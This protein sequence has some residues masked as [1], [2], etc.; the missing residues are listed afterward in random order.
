M[1][2]S[3][4]MFNKA[5]QVLRAYLELIK[6]IYNK[7]IANMILHGE[8]TKEFPLKSGIRLECPSLTLLLNIAFQ[9]LAS[10]IR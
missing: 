4:K 3:Q 8:N 2:S 5:E 6:A 10:A 1:L 9:N 7:F